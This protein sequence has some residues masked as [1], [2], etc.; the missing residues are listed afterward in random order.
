MSA[1]L[2][3]QSGT[4]DRFLVQEK[5]T[6]FV[7]AGSGAPYVPVIKAD[8]QTCVGVLH[9]IDAILVPPYSVLPIP[10]NPASALLCT[11]RTAAYQRNLHQ[12]KFKGTCFFI[13]IHPS[14]TKLTHSCYQNFVK[15]FL[16]NFNYHLLQFL[17]S[18]TDSNVC[19]FSS[20][21][22]LKQPDGKW[23][24]TCNTECSKRHKLSPSSF[25]HFSP[26]LPT[27]T[28]SLVTCYVLFCK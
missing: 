25:P 15:G 20:S 10:M 17:R 18:G 28:L 7:A 8:I 23:C 6:I 4:S 3:H 19:S 16:Y 13:S 11:G 27:C 2:Q 5:Q 21:N 24:I 26:F 1:T 14:E 9:I 12:H 22:Y